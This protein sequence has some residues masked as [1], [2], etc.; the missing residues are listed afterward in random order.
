MI[1]VFLIVLIPFISLFSVYSRLQSDDLCG[2]EINEFNLENL[3]VESAFSY[4]NSYTFLDSSDLYYDE[5]LSISKSTL[6]R[7]YNDNCSYLGGTYYGAPSP[8]IVIALKTTSNEKIFL[9]FYELESLNY[10]NRYSVDI[11]YYE[12]GEPVELR[13]NNV[14]HKMI[15]EFMK[16]K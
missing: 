7:L 6:E 9:S 5:F 3:I 15:T 12:N 10:S 2:I 13:F 4:S 1:I 16:G 14:E 11:V 8:V